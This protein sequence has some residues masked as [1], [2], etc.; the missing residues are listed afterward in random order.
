MKKKINV[1][2]MGLDFNS[3]N[4]GCS[5]LGYSFLSVLENVAENFGCQ[6]ELISVNYSSASIDGKNFVFKDLPIRLKRPGFYKEFFGVLPQI[7]IAIDFTG[8]DSFT[9]LYGLKRFIRETAFKQAVL[10][11][12]KPLIFGP[13][14][15]G[16]FSKKF[17]KKWAGKVLLK[18]EE[19]FTRD[20]ISR[21]YAQDEFGMSS[22]LTTDIAFMLPAD[23]H[24]RC[25]KDNVTRIGINISGLMWHGGYTGKN[26]LGI[27]LDYKQLIAMLIKHLLSEG[28]EIWLIPHVLPDDPNNPENDYRAMEE[29]K[30]ISKE[31]NLAPK[32]KTPMEAKR[33]MAGMDFFIG[34]RMHAT[35]GAFSMG[36][37]TV[38]VAYSRKFQGLYNSINYPYVID[39]KKVTAESAFS[40]II[41]W[42]NNRD[43][44]KNSVQ[45]SLLIVEHKNKEF[46]NQITEIFR[47]I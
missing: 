25:E 30:E 12:H 33:F 10:C 47:N 2:L 28:F 41:Q 4:L 17:S 29:V 16:P 27:C 9:D 36:V 31:I 23:E 14:T 35:I 39:A 13:Q 5:A 1:L 24:A 32:F 43:E 46:I 6:F 40:T 38:S 26:E 15:I 18:S 44:L 45:E 3:K 22:I 21:K 42:I 37:P 20:E 11:K 8:G 34:S 19:V 7:D